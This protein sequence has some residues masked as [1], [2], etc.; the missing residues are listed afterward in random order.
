MNTI[1]AWAIQGHTWAVDLLRNSLIAGNLAH[2]TLLAGPPNIGNH[3]LAA[4][5]AQAILCESSDRA[6]RP[7]GRCRA[8]RLVEAGTHPDLHTLRPPE[9]ASS[10]DDETKRIIPVETVREMRSSVM[11]RPYQGDASVV[12]VD[13]DY[14]ND[15]GANTLLKIVEEPPSYL[16][17][18][19]LA[20]DAAAVW[21]TI[22]SRCQILQLRPLPIGEV[23][24]ALEA[25]G[26]A[27]EQAD[28]LARLSGGRI[29]WA[30][31]IVDNPAEL[32][33]RNESLQQVATLANA[34]R[35]DRFAYASKLAGQFSKDPVTVRQT[36]ALWL[37][38]W[39][40]VLLITQGCADLITNIDH[41]ST[42]TQ[43]AQSR[44][45]EAVHTFSRAIET[46]M[47]HL[48]QNV[49]PTLA[50]E[51]MLLSLPGETF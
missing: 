40:D 34:S 16:Y 18:L 46:A 22:T 50:L 37:S 43:L 38:W 31:N 33:T 48:E 49:N 23:Q 44:D 11:Q 2:S 6:A 10:D 7:C 45:P 14:L 30:I 24:A 39:R 32:E 42:L 29:G 36:L 4:L 9:A 5:L 12:M 3:T 1:T 8:C 20:R 41:R 13:I 21:P 47:R 25:R 35:T 28:L 15:A 19:L 17:F 27:T 26:V 51:V